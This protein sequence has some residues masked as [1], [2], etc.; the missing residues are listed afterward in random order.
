M[1]TAH[2]VIVEAIR[3]KRRLSFVYD[4]K[5]RV[6]EPQCH[7]IGSKGTLLLRAAQLHAGPHPERLF[8]VARITRLELL[9]ERFDGPGPHYARDDSA[10]A[11]VFAQ[12]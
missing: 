2:P 5:P 11:E 10:M 8:D 9:D 7:G 3:D 12:L 4:E 6:V 1:P